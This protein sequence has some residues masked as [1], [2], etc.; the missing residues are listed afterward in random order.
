M[1]FAA[2]IIILSFIKNKI[3]LFLRFILYKDACSSKK[4]ARMK[5][6]NALCSLK[7]RNC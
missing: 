1:K 4:G 2:K 7:M 3:L 5:I 6:A